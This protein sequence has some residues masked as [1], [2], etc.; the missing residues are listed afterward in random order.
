VRH[1]LATKTSNIRKW[2]EPHRVRAVDEV[3]VGDP[4]IGS[5]YQ[6]R[7]AIRFLLKMLPGLRWCRKSGDPVESTDR[8]ILRQVDQIEPLAHNEVTDPAA[9]SHH[10]SLR[11]DD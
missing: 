10:Q 11:Q 8:S 6:L 3:A 4:C 7:P 2:T 1:Q 5:D 9:G